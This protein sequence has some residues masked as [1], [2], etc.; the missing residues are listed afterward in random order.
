MNFK[1]IFT[2]M[3]PVFFKNDIFAFLIIGLGRIRVF[4]IFEK[5]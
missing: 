2:Q 4:F 3:D 1:L 5:K